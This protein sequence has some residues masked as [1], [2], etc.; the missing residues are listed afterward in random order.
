MSHNNGSTHGD[1][2]GCICIRLVSRTFRF[3]TKCES[4]VKE[5]VYV[6]KESELSRL[7]LCVHLKKSPFCFGQLSFLLT[8]LA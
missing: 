6:F 5:N 4:T 7:Q 3:V 1:R 2:V 8:L